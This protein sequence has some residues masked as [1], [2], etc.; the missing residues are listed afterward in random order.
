VRLLQTGG[1]IEIDELPVIEADAVQMRL[2]LQNLL[3]NALKF[4]RPGVQP[5][6][7]ITSQ[8]AAINA[9]ELKVEDN[10]IG[11]DPSYAGEL[12][13]PF[14][15][16]HGKSTYEGTGMGLTICRKIAERH[17]GSI[18]AKSDPGNGSTFTVSLP[19]KQRI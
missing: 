10:G 1:R 5:Q 17:G 18:S 12:F 19:I 14:H 7:K 16:L 9:I 2:L 15:R 4:H 11:F 3:G 13:Q 6:V 8:P